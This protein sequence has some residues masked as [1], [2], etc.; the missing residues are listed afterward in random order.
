[1][2][3][4]VPTPAAVVD[5]MVGRL[6]HRRPPG[7]S[8]TLLDPGCG[9]GAFIDGVLRWC[10][11]RGLVPPRMVGVEQDPLRASAAAA[12]F[13][14]NKRVE[15]RAADFLADLDD[16]FDYIVG[17]PPYVSILGLDDAER[18]R[19]RSKFRTARGR[20]DL[21]FLFFEQA[22]R[23]LK[24]NGR[25][26]FVTPEKYLYVESAKV[27]RTL[28][29]QNH[30]ES[31][32]LIPENSFPDVTAY[33]AITTLHGG[34]P[35]MSRVIHRDGSTTSVRLDGTLR[36]WLSSHRSAE[37]WLLGELVDRISCGVATGADDVFILPAQV[38]PASLQR[39]SF[40]SIGGRD[41]HGSNIPTRLENSILV[42]YRRNG[43][44]MSP[45]EMGPLLDFLRNHRRRLEERT[46]AIRKPWYAFHE[47]PLLPDLLRPKLLCKD[48][49]PEPRFWTDSTGGTFPR[50]SVYYVQP[51]VPS[52][53][54]VLE[55]Y[56][57]SEEARKWLMGNCQRATNKFLRL[58]SNVLKQLPVPDDVARKLRHEKELLAA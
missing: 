48:I 9:E 39:F 40:P 25:L 17:N 4:F 26:V 13:R 32:Q 55:S 8:M 41:L 37:G 54:P 1:M 56:L 43:G 36:S 45:S 18:Q 6:F 19:Y 11:D 33:P 12:R 2:K 35:G 52:H 21:Y 31:I 5:Q 3:G 47:T 28:L 27:L 30:I 44:L 49:A 22:L 16:Q 20:F 51:R 14:A 58:Q 46:C 15:I 23:A 50:H 29:A 53:L 34:S 57:H 24:P 38:V 10:K 42:P 7:P